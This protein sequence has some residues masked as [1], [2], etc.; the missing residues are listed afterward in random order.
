MASEKWQKQMKKMKEN[1]TY[2]EF[3][4]RRNLL[5]HKRLGKII[6]IEPKIR[7]KGSGTFING[8]KAYRAK[9]KFLLEHVLVMS[10]H[11][12]RELVK[13]ETIHHKNGI[14][15]DN[16]IENLELWSN[17][18]PGGQRVQD[19]LKWCREFIKQYESYEEKL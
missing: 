11:L 17:R 2:D 7:E 12:G 13:G 15:D 8:Y 5:Q 14:R 1:G 19:K 9:G 16:R 4:K 3:K 6:D 10:K 18:H